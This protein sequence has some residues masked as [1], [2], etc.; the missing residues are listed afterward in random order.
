MQEL[1]FVILW[2][3]DSKFVQE[4]DGTQSQMYYCSRFSQNLMIFGGRVGG[5]FR[6]K[7][8]RV[9]GFFVVVVEFCL[10]GF[11]LDLL[12]TV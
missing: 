10:F 5:F 11:G 7:G 12:R 2:F 1:A 3:M 8:W 9:W 4:L 6:L